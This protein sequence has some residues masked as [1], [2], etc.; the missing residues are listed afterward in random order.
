MDSLSPKERAAL[1]ATMAELGGAP[2]LAQVR[3]AA[4]LVQDAAYRC[5]R[6]L[7]PDRLVG[8]M[9][10]SAELERLTRD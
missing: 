6:L 9:R 8:L 10:L 1:V 5:A 3:V 4:A 2:P 7:P